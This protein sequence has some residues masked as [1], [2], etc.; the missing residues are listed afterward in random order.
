M[1]Y[2]HIKPEHL[3]EW[4]N[5]TDENT[6]IDSYELERLSAEWEISETELLNDLEEFFPTWMEYMEKHPDENLSYCKPY[7]N[8]NED[9]FLIMFEGRA[10]SISMPNGI[11]ITDGEP[12]FSDALRTLA[13]TVNEEYELYSGWDDTHIA[14][15]TMH[16]T[17][18]SRCPFCKDWCDA[19]SDTIS[20]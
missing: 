1:K 2:Y 16:E 19:M 6:V 14:L 17:G 8:D 9:Y 12:G 5:H 7:T 10:A 20:D 11:R 13:R 15:E 18:C 3:T 4:G